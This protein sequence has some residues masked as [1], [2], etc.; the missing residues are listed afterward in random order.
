LPAAHTVRRKTLANTVVACGAEDKQYFV[1]CGAYRKQIATLSLCLA[2]H[3]TRTLQDI[4]TCHSCTALFLKK[5]RDK[6]RKKE[7]KTLATPVL[8]DF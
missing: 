6:D 2:A 1:L 4:D 7:R 5:K 8:F 3:K